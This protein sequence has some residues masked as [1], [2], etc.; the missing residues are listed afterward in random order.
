MYRITEISV[1]SHLLV[2]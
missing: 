2:L 1:M